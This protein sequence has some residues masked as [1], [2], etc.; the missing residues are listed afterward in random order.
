MLDK[1][2][3]IAYL[4]CVQRRMKESFLKGSYNH[5]LGIYPKQT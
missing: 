3:N 2:E 4:N 1:V 5:I